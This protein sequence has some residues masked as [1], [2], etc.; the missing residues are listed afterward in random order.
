MM[1]CKVA[2]LDRRSP[3]VL[4]AALL[5][6]IGKP[7][8]RNL[9]PK[10]GHVRF[11][12][13]EAVSAFLALPI[14]KR[15]IDEGEIDPTDA[16]RVFEL[17]ALHTLLH[18]DHPHRKLKE[19]FAMRNVTLYDELISL[20]RADALGSFSTMDTWSDHKENELR[21]IGKLDGCDEARGKR[22][23]S[24]ELILAMNLD[25]AKRH[26]EKMHPGEA[27][28]VVDSQKRIADI[29]NETRSERI[30]L[31]GTI[32]TTELTRLWSE[33]DRYTV[34]VGLLPDFG[35]ID[36]HR[37]LTHILRSLGEKYRHPIGG[38]IQN[39]SVDWES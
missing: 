10:N 35:A 11:G 27:P 7:A 21:T 25:A 16:S 12:G 31:M 8:V 30:T 33:N 14:L 1:V 22:T 36:P 13:H 23:V 20:N 39:F 38:A 29:L 34:H 2:Q 3:T 24:V 5:H 6:D 26:W 19:W 32:D 37:P 17:I 28:I 15:L 18:Q 9:N 4:L